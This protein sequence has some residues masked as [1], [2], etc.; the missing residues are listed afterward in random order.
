MVHTDRPQQLHPDRLPRWKELGD[1]AVAALLALP[2]L[3]GATMTTQWSQLLHPRE[4]HQTAVAQQRAVAEKLEQG[5]T[6]CLQG[7]AGQHVIAWSPRDADA[8]G[9]LMSHFLRSQRDAVPAS[10]CF[11]ATLPT[12]PGAST[13]AHFL[14]LWT[15]PLLRDKYASLVRA[16][17]LMPQ[18]VE[19][20]LPGRLGP[21]QVCQGLACF[22]V[23]QD[24]KRSPPTVILPRAPLVQASA[25]ESLTLDTPTAQLPQLMA[26]L[27]ALEEFRG[28]PPGTSP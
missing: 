25:R 17:Y 8:L 4:D 14:D 5:D 27:A 23:S 3:H 19:M 20:V 28:G 6:R 24:G 9:R 12:L 16:V 22:W 18:P 26:R 13:P 1:A 15:H 7:L 2:G 11:L 10:I 21:R